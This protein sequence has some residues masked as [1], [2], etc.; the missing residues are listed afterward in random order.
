[1]RVPFVLGTAPVAMCT[2]DHAA[3]WAKIAAQ[4]LADS[5]AKV[6]VDSARVDSAAR[7]P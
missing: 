4:R 5:L 1:M 7:E 3:D 2:K 6:P